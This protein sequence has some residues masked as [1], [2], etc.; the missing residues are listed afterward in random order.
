MTTDPQTLSATA[1]PVS[2]EEEA[3]GL[4]WTCVR[5]RPRWEKKFADWASRHDF[6]HYLPLVRRRT[7][8]HRKVR[9]SY[10]PLF[11]GYVFLL[12]DLGKKDFQSSGAVVHCLK[13]T[14]ERQ[15]VQLAMDLWSVAQ[16]LAS[17]QSP[18][19]V[20]SWEPGEKVRLVGGA[21]AGV[22]GEIVRRESDSLFIVAIEF[23]GVATAI[24]VDETL[25]AEPL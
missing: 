15:R 10:L 3:R 23:L 24:T 14:S 2:L 1:F 11:P 16:L 18:V 22:T 5:T 9:L 13:P 12:G 17:G 20:P 21:L 19:P 6:T 7:V 8:S 25:L 4:F